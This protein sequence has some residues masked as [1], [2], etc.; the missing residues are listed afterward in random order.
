MIRHNP[1]VAIAFEDELEKLAVLRHRDL[2]AIGAGTGAMLNLGARA[3]YHAGVDAHP[4]QKGRTLVGDVVKG[5]AAAIAAKVLLD[6]LSRGKVK[7]RI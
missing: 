2:A 7:R 4:A 1:N 6:V 3:K 5:G